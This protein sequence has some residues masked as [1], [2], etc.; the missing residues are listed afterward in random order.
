MVIGFGPI[1][2]AIVAFGLRGVRDFERVPGAA[3]GE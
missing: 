1:L 3:A 2:S